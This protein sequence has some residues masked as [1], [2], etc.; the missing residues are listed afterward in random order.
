MDYLYDPGPPPRKRVLFAVRDA[1]VAAKLR[2]DLADANLTT[3]SP[4][5]ECYEKDFDIIVVCF[6]PYT[7]KDQMWYHTKVLPLLNSNGVIY[8]GI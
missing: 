7:A 1:V 3:I 2:A 6:E 4:D 5:V 8:W